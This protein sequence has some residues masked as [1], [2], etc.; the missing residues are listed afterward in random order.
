MLRI[1][2]VSFSGKQFI[3]ALGRRYLEMNI[4]GNTIIS[5]QTV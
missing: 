4:K 3:I 2:M 1:N 5:E